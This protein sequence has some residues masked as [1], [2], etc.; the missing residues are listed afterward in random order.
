MS[1]AIQIARSFRVW[2]FE[3]GVSKRLMRAVLF[4]A[5]TA[6]ASFFGPTAAIA[7]PNP[8]A[9]P[10]RDAAGDAEIAKLEK[11]LGALK[12][13]KWR[14]QT[15]RDESQ[16]ALDDRIKDSKNYDM[17]GFKQRIDDDIARLT[18]DIADFDAALARNAAAI[19]DIEAKIAALKALPPCPPGTAAPPAGPG[20]TPT[21]VPP[22]HPCRTAEDDAAIEAL[23]KEKELDERELSLLQ[24]TIRHLGASVGKM[25]RRIKNGTASEEDKRNFQAL[26]RQLTDYERQ[27]TDLEA[28][29]AALDAKIRALASLKPC[30]HWTTP[31]PQPGPSEPGTTPQPGKPTT[32]PPT[33]VPG[34]GTP[35]VEPKPAPPVTPAPTPPTATQPA[36]PAKP[37]EPDKRDEIGK[38]IELGGGED[39]STE[40][41]KFGHDDWNTSVFRGAAAVSFAIPD[42]DMSAQVG[43]R[44]ETDQSDYKGGFKTNQ[45][46]FDGDAHVTWHNLG[47]TLVGAF[48][49]YGSTRAGEFMT[50]GAEGQLIYPQ[51]TLYAQALGHSGADEG[52]ADTPNNESAWYVQGEARYFETD[53]LKFS[54]NAGF[55]GISER[56]YDANAL[57][58]SAQAEYR[59]EDMPLSV[60]VLYQGSHAN[61]S[62]N[63][64]GGGHFQ[65]D[66]NGIFAGVRLYLDESLL[67]ENDRVTA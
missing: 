11:D 12:D 51:T 27:R 18:H 25:G 21:P 32:P 29:I 14:L 17:R 45:T 57:R 50:A 39:W 13:H 15:L 52:T 35:P 67:R 4:G 66:S 43:G 10:C 46:S 30:E 6:A 59:F 49:S 20:V 3:A 65:Q 62:A 33:P 22:A 8:A 37:E 16:K 5:L 26:D 64:A 40:R 56:F 19:R 41:S 38:R 47:S 44:V 58:W 54:V 9:A 60:F 31:Q 42:T 28:E 48:A 53:N 63:F 61:W 2:K 24:K 7:Q 36:P 55:A 34:P 23:K 1:H